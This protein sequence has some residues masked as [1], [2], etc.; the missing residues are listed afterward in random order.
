MTIELNEAQVNFLKR[1]GITDPIVH[2]TELMAFEDFIQTIYP[3]ICDEA[4]SAVVTLNA[5]EEEEEEDAD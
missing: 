2:L 3:D 1:N 5:D 4:W